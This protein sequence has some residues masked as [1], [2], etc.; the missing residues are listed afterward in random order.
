MV[1]RNES[2]AQELIMPI[3]IL[4]T[5]HYLFT[6]CSIS[7]CIS[8]HGSIWN[9][10]EFLVFGWNYEI[11]PIRDNIHVSDVAF[12]IFSFFSV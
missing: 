7:I 9:E 10:S 11:L 2:T 5:I 12:Q 8:V 4:H 3:K 6:V 1:Y